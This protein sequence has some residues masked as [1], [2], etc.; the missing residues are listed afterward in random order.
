MSINLS[1]TWYMKVDDD[2]MTSV[3]RSG[4]TPLSR[5]AASRDQPVALD[6]HA[7]FLA[8]HQIRSEPTIKVCSGSAHQARRISSQDAS[9]E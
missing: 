8:S 6:R 9:M 1:C 3:A 4:T 5:R 7:R 2:R